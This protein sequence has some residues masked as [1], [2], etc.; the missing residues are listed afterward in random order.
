MN[1]KK[2]VNDM[3]ESVLR[4]WRRH[5]WSIQGLGMLRTYINPSLR[6][7]IWSSDAQTKG[8]SVMH[9][10]PWDF[11][12]YVVA[13]C[14]ADTTYREASHG[15]IYSRALYNRQVIKCG[16]GGGPVGSPESV[17]LEQVGVERY[18]AGQSYAHDAED[19][20]SSA[21]DNGTV[22]LVQRHFKEDTELARVYWDTDGRWGS[23]E[24]R[25]AVASEIAPIV[26]HS[27]E[28]YFRRDTHEQR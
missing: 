23:A 12:S 10:H 6:L 1:H 8:A 28:T 26:E 24:P 7:H 9:T 18:T 5:Q 14:M 27:L 4:H 25:V 15:G 11:E 3:T 20:H 16:S 13:G 17:Y 22:T 21:F 2:L 19:I